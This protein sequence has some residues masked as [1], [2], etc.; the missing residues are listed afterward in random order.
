MS[1]TLTIASKAISATVKPALW[2]TETFVTSGLDMTGVNVTLVA[3]DVRY[4]AAGVGRH[5]A[6][7]IEGTIDESGN[8]TFADMAFTTEEARAVFTSSREAYIWL[9]VW[10]TDNDKYLATGQI[11]M[12][13]AP[14]PDSQAVTLVGTSFVSQ[15][16]LTAAIAAHAA[17]ASPHSGITTNAS[18]LTTHNAATA[19]HTALKSC[20]L[21]TSDAADE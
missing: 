2:D 12:A 15:A 16:Q 21:Y 19:S 8:A 4:V 1:I 18:N 3:C 14:K 9:G 7:A 6:T 10:D 5:I 11:K 17:L 20:L 13:Y